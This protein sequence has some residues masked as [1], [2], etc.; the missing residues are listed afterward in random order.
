[1]I[2]RI[3]NDIKQSLENECY[4]A[5]LSLALILPDMCGRVE[6]PNT[7]NKSRYTGWCEKYLSEKYYTLNCPDKKTILDG[8]TIYSLRCC[9][10]HEGNPTIEKERGYAG[11]SLITEKKV[12][13]GPYK[14]RVISIREENGDLVASNYLSVNLGSLCET[15][16]EAAEN[17]YKEN[18]DRF[19]FYYNIINYDTNKS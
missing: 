4:F 7:G 11:F 2:Y 17:Y 14:G 8:E 1:M 9:V 13:A 18:K 6:S 12:G 5:A 19:R 16:C 15:I 3:I 10:L